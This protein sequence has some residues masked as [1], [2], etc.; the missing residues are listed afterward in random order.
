MWQYYAPIGERDGGKVVV[1]I[2]QRVREADQSLHE[3]SCRSGTPYFLYT[4]L[5]SSSISRRVA[6]V[7]CIDSNHQPTQTTLQFL[8]LIH[9]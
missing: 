6:H 5:P 8:Y 9:L 2:R 1:C 4:F 3:I 7:V